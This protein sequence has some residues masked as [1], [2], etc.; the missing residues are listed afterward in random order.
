MHSRLPQRVIVR[1]LRLIHRK[2]IEI[3]QKYNLKA[4][5]FA[6]FNKH[7]YN[8]KLRWSG[9]DFVDNISV[10]TLLDLEYVDCVYAHFISKARFAEENEHTSK[11]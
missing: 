3:L 2:Y 9:D 1:R 5:I 4:R 11:N 8:L 6:H 10:L 7:K